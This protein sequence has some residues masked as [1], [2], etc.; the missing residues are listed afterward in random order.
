MPLVNSKEMLLKAQKNRYAIGAFNVENMEMM[1]AVIAAAQ[2]E[3]APVILQTTPSTLNYADTSLF[4]SMARALAEKASVPIAI[5]LDHGNSYNLC[6][7]AAEDGYTSLMIDGSKLPI[8]E[9][10]SLSRQ[11]VQLA[12]AMSP[13]LSVEAELGRLGGKED[14]VEVKHGEDIYT[15]PDEAARFA[16]E[17]GVDSLA[18][19]IGTA[20]GFYKGDPMLDFE[21]LALLKAAVSIPLVLHGSSGVSDEDVRRAISLGVCKVNFATELRVAYTQAAR[22]C[23]ESDIA[24]YDPKK[25]GVPARDAVTDIVRHRIRTCGAQNQA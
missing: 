24:I 2:A 23:L 10:I 14:A 7:Q 15:D 11:V 20:H 22:Q 9:N 21:R 5:H 12:S 8:E 19:A 25:Y 18:V 16:N 6:R 4:V 1:Q 17:T 13:A 3:N